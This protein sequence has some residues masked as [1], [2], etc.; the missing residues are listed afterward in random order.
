MTPELRKAAIMRDVY[1]A[2]RE[3]EKDKP[4]VFLA[5]MLLNEAW[6]LLK[7]EAGQYA[8]PIRSAL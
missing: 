6:E 5:E 4:N 1:N 7:E 8:T 3:L 2:R